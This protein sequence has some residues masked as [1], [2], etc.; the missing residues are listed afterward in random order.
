MLRWEKGNNKWLGFDDDTVLYYVEPDC[1]D[2]TKWQ[3]VTVDPNGYGTY[4]YDTAEEAMKEADEDWAENQIIVGGE[5][6]DPI[7]TAEEL[8]EIYGDRLYDE[9]KENELMGW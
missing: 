4:A 5:D 3:W 8:E 1:D 7:F 6:D 9:C 2:P